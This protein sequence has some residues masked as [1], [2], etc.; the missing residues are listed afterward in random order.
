MYNWNMLPE[1]K[2]IVLIYPWK[3]L[4]NASFA[5]PLKEA[6]WD[7]HDESKAEFMHGLFF[8]FT[9]S[10]FIIDIIYARPISANS[11]FL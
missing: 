11:F 3:N 9:P 1:L 2:K 6:G 7:V 8:A 4:V 10:F 5:E